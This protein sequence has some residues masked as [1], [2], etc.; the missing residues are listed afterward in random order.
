MAN[1]E[2]PMAVHT[3]AASS[4][5]G[6][7]NLGCFRQSAFLADEVA[8]LRANKT[9]PMQHSARYAHPAMC[10]W[11][12]RAI[13]IS[14]FSMLNRTSQTN[15]LSSA[16]RSFSRYPKPQANKPNQ[17]GQPCDCDACDYHG[18][19]FSTAAAQPICCSDLVTTIPVSGETGSAKCCRGS[20]RPAQLASPAW[21]AAALDQANVIPFKRR[22]VG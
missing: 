14:Q 15:L 4:G 12:P 6:A 5:Y 22:R 17:E 16:S 7:R 10:V 19:N 3:W 13:P 11:S 8:R 18:P 9:Y 1:L 20:S 21:R 2:P